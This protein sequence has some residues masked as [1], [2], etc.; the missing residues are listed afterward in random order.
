MAK[1]KKPSRWAAVLARL[2]ADPRKTSRILTFLGIVVGTLITVSVWVLYLPGRHTHEH[3]QTEQTRLRLAFQPYLE[4]GYISSLAPGATRFINTVPRFSSLQARA[5]RVDWIHALPYEITFLADRGDL[6][7]VPMQVFVNPIPDNDSFVGEVNAWGAL[8]RIPVVRWKGSKLNPVAERQYTAGGTVPVP[9]DAA[10]LLRDWRGQTEALPAFDKTHAM[11]L[12]ADNG[13]G[14]LLALHRAF[15]NDLW[16]WASP[17]SNEALVQAWPQIATLEVL[18]DLTRDDEFTLNI[19]IVGTPQ[20]NPVPLADLVATLATE[21]DQF[22]SEE[23][24]MRFEGAGNWAD[25]VRF[26][27]TY[28]LSGFEARIRR[29]WGS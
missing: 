10:A 3:L 8:D 6:D 14:V 5:F 27:G 24:G 21:F 23:L 13:D 9:G 11:E 4:Q 15:R 7:T 19:T 22:L 1:R 29:A 12:F 18:G 2:Q 25:G 17:E 28:R 20:A 26:A 16:D